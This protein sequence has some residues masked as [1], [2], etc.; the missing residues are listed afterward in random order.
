MSWDF[1]LSWKCPGI[2]F[3]PGN[4]LGDDPFLAE[5]PGK[6]LEF[7][8]LRFKIHKLKNVLLAGNIFI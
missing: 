4:V 5:G 2:L 7:L 1:I 6:V 3:C 8:V